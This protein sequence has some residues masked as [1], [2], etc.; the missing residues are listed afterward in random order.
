MSKHSGY[1]WADINTSRPSKYSNVGIAMLEA[2]TEALSAESRAAAPVSR[3]CLGSVNIVRRSFDS[4]IYAYSTS[5]WHF[6]KLR[7]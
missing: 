1:T 2:V 7:H 6:V 3:T 4:S 5:D